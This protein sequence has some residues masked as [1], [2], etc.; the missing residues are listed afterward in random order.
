[1]FERYTEKARRVIFFA[2]YEASQFGSSYIET[3]H[4]L[5][6]LFREDKG[7]ANQFLASHAKL[8]DIRRSITQRSQTSPRVATSVDLPGTDRAIGSTRRASHVA[9]SPGTTLAPEVTTGGLVT[10]GSRAHRPG[11]GTN[12]ASV[13]SRAHCAVPRRSVT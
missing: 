2:R 4:L 10:P 6:G 1:M 3:E 9:P 5:L 7:L 12:A 11:R 13:D 8:E